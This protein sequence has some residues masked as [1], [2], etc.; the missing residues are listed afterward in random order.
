M[1]RIKERVRTLHGDLMPVGLYI[2]F[3]KAWPAAKE[4]METEGHTG[5]RNV[6]PVAEGPLN[7]PSCWKYA[8]RLS[9]SA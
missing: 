7:R 8:S 4:F 2:S 1:S 3:A 6:Q 5:P 9:G